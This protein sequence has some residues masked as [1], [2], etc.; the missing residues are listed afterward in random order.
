MLCVAWVGLVA[1]VAPACAWAEAR[2]TLV[3]QLSDVARG[4]EVSGAREVARRL[5]LVAAVSMALERE[6]FWEVVP[7]VAPEESRSTEAS[8][9]GR[10]RRGA[11][12]AADCDRSAAAVC[13]WAHAAE[14]NMFVAALGHAEL[15]P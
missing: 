12:D 11:L 10:T 9:L 3:L 1:G 5:T 7:Q 6:S 4:R 2:P 15:L 14:E 8:E 13:A